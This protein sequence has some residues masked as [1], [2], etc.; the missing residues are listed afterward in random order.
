[1]SVFQYSLVFDT[2]LTRN[3]DS[4]ALANLFQVLESG[5]GII[6]ACL[7]L[8]RQPI[9]KIWPK[10]VGSSGRRTPYYDDEVSDQH[11]MQ[12][13]SNSQAESQSKAWSASDPFRSRPR[14]SD[15]LGIISEGAETKYGDSGN[16]TGGYTLGMSDGIRKDMVYSVDRR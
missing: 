4:F 3:A 7:P 14:K 9:K 11:V 2:T 5:M 1:M 15:E 13:V 8:M 10:L 12:N 16:E 6:G